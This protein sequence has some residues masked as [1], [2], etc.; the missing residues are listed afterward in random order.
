MNKQQMKAKAKKEAEEYCKDISKEK[1]VND[2]EGIANLIEEKN[3]L[4]SAATIR[5]VAKGI[6][7]GGLK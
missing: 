6:K 5:V 7:K 4:N 3:C 1:L 2:L